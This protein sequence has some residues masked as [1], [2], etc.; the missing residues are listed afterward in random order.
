MVS[1]LN[2]RTSR[3]VVYSLGTIS[4]LLALAGCGNPLAQDDA[5]HL[6]PT[7]FG[8]RPAR[9][10]VTDARFTL[11]WDAPEDDVS[12]YRIYI[13]PHRRSRWTLLADGLVEPLLTIDSSVIAAG[14]YEFAVS[15]V[16][17]AG[18]ESAK[19]TSLDTT[20]EPHMGWYLTWEP[21]EETDP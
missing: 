5:S 15:Y 1:A 8:P 20:A 12:G 4:V 16:S 18:V 14:S 11:L 10:R 21:A 3:I 6:G 17:S 9:I 7:A 13:R 2:V 19:H